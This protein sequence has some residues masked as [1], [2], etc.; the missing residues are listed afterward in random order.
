MSD[1]APQDQ[2]QVQNQSD[3][4]TDDQAESQQQVETPVPFDYRPLYM[5]STHERARLEAEIEKL[6][7]Q[8]NAPPPQMQ[9]SRQ[10]TDD[11][12][13][14]RPAESL[15]N[16]VDNRLR[17]ALASTMGPM[18]EMTQA[19]RQQTAMAQAEAATFRDLPHLAAIANDPSAIAQIRQRAAQFGPPTKASYQEALFA[20][21][22]QFAA[23]NLLPQN[24]NFQQNSQQNSPAPNQREAVPNKPTQGRAPVSASATRLTEAEKSAM[25]GARL[26]P[27]KP[28]DVIEFQRL[29]SDDPY[30]IS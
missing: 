10:I 9:Q 27:S 17:E 3:Q 13:R 6:T 11:D 12:I 14:E 28:A 29:I 18:N 16:L 20:A 26:D 4:S 30:V 7:Q 24:Q 1:E 19:Y 5:D 8:R 23:A 22:G 2:S 15:S 21:I 25:R